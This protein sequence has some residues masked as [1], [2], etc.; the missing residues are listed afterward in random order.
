MT[1]GCRVLTIVAAAAVLLVTPSGAVA[2][3][4]PATELMRARSFCMFCTAYA[5]RIIS[6]DEAFVAVVRSRRAADQLQSV[7]DGGNIQGKMYALAGLREI[8]RR[9][10]DAN[11]RR[12]TGR[13]FSVVLV[14]TENP[15]SVLRERGDVVLQRIRRGDYSV[16]V[17]WATKGRL[18]R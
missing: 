16:F 9:R 8:D 17:E 2:R 1:A 11:L 12:I 7:F 3:S 10:F 14:A 5:G 4:A 18:S 6:G 13:S 15:A